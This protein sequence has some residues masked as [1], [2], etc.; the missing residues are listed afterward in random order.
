MNLYQIYS[1]EQTKPK[2]VLFPP[3]LLML[4]KIGSAITSQLETHR[5]KITALEQDLDKQRWN[6]LSQKI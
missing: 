4:N 2:A 1:L 3:L 5:L 6:S